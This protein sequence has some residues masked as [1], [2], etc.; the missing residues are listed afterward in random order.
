MQLI[1]F[2]QTV[3]Q[4]WNE[5]KVPRLAASLSYYTVFSLVPFLVIVIYVA[6]LVIGTSAAQSQV[7]GQVS[8]LVGPEGAQL[9][10]SML[11]SAWKL[12]TS[13]V[14]FVLGIAAILLGATGIVGE[15]KDSLNTIWNV[16]PKPGR[17]LFGTFLERSLSF[18]M[19]LAIG[20]LLL[21]SLAV[22]AGLAG[23]NTYFARYFAEWVILGRVLDLL[24]SLL[25]I[26]GMFA[27]MFKYLTDAKIA[28]R[29][30]LLGAF[31]TAV[32]FTIGKF[33]IGLYLGN[34]NIA[35]PFGAAGSLIILFVWVY[36]A[37]QILFLGA[38][39]TQVY[40]NQ[41]GVGIKPA[42]DAVSLSDAARVEQGTKAPADPSKPPSPVAVPTVSIVPAASEPKYGR[43]FSLTE[44]VAAAVGVRFW[45]LIKSLF[46]LG[47][48]KSYSSSRS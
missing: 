46:R 20:F 34:S 16:T 48:P 17:G 13:L 7:V 42:A 5:D 41:F 28:W 45:S 29:D 14:P 37:A 27:A 22:S 31:V 11:D 9:V 8:G 30:A 26:T 23:L 2:F 12:D 18:G 33:A 39:I 25:I 47:H 4:E 6:G 1:P 36:Y 24:V 15:L 32:L 21:V 35:T 44:F 38:E 10:N 43:A 3:F 19:V 40:A